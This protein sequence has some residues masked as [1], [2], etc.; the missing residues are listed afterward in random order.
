[1]PAAARRLRL[2]AR[3]S[4]WSGLSGRA[5]PA[6]LR[7]CERNHEADHRAEDRGTA[8][9]RIATR[10]TATFGAELPIMPGGMHR[11]GKAEPVTAAAQPG[12]L[13]LLTALT[14]PHP[15]TLR[16]SPYNIPAN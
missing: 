15:A 1:M 14:S 16:A 5:D 3:I 8:M 7:R 4:G 6:D 9:T 13:R 12:G 2:H 10:F 11:V